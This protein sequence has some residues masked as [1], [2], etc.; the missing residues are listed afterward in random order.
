MR[1]SQFVFSVSAQLTMLHYISY[2]FLAFCYTVSSL[3][4]C[5]VLS[6]PKLADVGN[7]YH[8]NQI[9]KWFF[10]LKMSANLPFCDNQWIWADF[11]LSSVQ[12]DLFPLNLFFSFPHFQSVCHFFLIHLKT[13]FYI[14][15]FISLS[16]FCDFCFGIFYIFSVLQ[17]PSNIHMTLISL[18][19][20][21][22]CG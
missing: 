12:L 4:L 11:H 6:S 2:N 7:F 16:L 8:L 18:C 5:R 9:S 17:K 14:K 10:F 20:V 19:S 13:Y 22:Y 1:T 21:F 15:S 3:A